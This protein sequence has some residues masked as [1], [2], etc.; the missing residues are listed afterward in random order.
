MSLKL[1]THMCLE[2]IFLTSLSL[3]FYKI[4]VTGCLV[5]VSLKGIYE[6]DGTNGHEK[7]HVQV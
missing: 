5:L 3:C 6:I 4:I 1:L 2:V 7:C